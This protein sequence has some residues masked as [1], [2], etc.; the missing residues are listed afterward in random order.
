VALPAAETAQDARPSQ[1]ESEAVS[2]YLQLQAQIHEARL[3]I[4]QSRLDA[5]RAAQRSSEMFAG[6]MK[7]V[8]DS[9]RT[10][11][12][13]MRI[14]RE[15][16]R[17]A[18][19]STS[20]FMLITLSSFAGAALLAVVLTAYFHWRA[21]GRIAQVTANWPASRATAYLPNDASMTLDDN[22]L[23][24]STAV[25]QSNARMTSVID[26]LER[27]ILEL[28]Q[29]AHGPLAE[30][31]GNGSGPAATT[32]ITPLS[33]DVAT[34]TAT[35]AGSVQHG[36]IDLLLEQGQTLLNDEKAEE[37]LAIFNQAIALEPN[38][39]EALV[40]KGTALEK[41]RKPQE[42]IACYDQA[43]ALDRAMTIA[44]LYKGGLFNRM[45][46]FSEAVECYEQAL[47]TQEI[48]VS[49]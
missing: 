39:T 3:A 18:F 29:A 35:S 4:E 8:A 38:H 44:Y 21:A 24:A 1:S 33:R 36:E 16:D 48:K 46:R 49:V 30:Q 11:L 23:I 15:K 41:L 6:Q 17:D 22:H 25:D 10:E 37:A 13:S 14:E 34:A 20:R 7:L 26:R 5:E 2:A 47:R 32:V 40:K 28:E 43:I 12:E 42:A 45:E 27:R 31:N 9:M 19:Q